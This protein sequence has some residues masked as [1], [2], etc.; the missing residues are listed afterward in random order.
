MAT[1][2]AKVEWSKGCDL[3]AHEVGFNKRLAVFTCPRSD[4]V[5]V[6]WKTEVFNASAANAPSG[7]AL[8]LLVW[9]IPKVMDGER[10]TA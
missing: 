9:S 1:H 10:K 4:V 5:K 7:S 6:A 3:C 8:D 2:W